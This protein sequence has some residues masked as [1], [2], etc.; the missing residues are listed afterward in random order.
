MAKT[1]KNAKS[2]NSR[3]PA[4]ARWSPAAIGWRPWLQGGAI[5]LLVAVTLGG[6]AWVG[7]PVALTDKAL[8]AAD[9]ALV[10]HGFAVTQLVVSGAARTPTPMIDRAAAIDYSRSILAVD[11]AA[12]RARVEAL[13][14]IREVA[15]A[16]RL[17]G[18]VMI[19]VS[20]REAVALWQHDQRF[21]LLDQ[22][23]LPII[24]VEARNYP[25]LGLVVGAG[26]NVAAADLRTLLADTPKLAERV[27]AAVRVGERRWDLQF[28]NGVTV[29]LPETEPAQAWRRLA[30][31]QARHGV[32][33]KGYGRLDLRQPGLLVARP[34]A[35]GPAVR[36][37]DDD[38]RAT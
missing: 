5:A 18:T 6:L 23:G 8:A 31:M 2:R 26:A 4:P 3:P 33:D 16:R 36:R 24:E 37:D 32:L 28:D 1:R 35:A 27:T 17:P 29:A 10:R 19:E 20:E 11:L 14:W 15:V 7:G 13:P 38:E 22:D 12:V 25:A 34:P 9:R 21:Y 30:F